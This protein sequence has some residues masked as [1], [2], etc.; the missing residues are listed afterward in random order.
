MASVDEGE[1]AGDGV[2]DV[3]DGLPVRAGAGDPEVGVADGDVG[4]VGAGLGGGLCICG[5]A[6]GRAGAG[7]RDGPGLVGAACPRAGPRMLGDRTGWWLGASRRAT[8][9]IATPETATTPPVA[10]PVAKARPVRAGLGTR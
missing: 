10:A 3:G 8:A 9:A 1:P 2:G 5:G 4:R 7:W 6:D